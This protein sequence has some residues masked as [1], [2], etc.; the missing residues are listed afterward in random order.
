MFAIKA[1]KLLGEGFLW[2]HYFGVAVK[3]SKREKKLAYDHKV[4]QLLD[5]YNQVL[6]AEADNIRSNQLQNVRKGVS[7]DSVVIMSKN[8]VLRQTI[9]AHAEKTGNKAYLNLIPL[10]YGNVSLIFTKGDLKEVHDE[11]AKFKKGVK[12][13][14]AESSLLTKLG[15]KPYSLVVHSVYDNGSVYRPEVLELTED[16]IYKSGASILA[17]LSMALSYPIVALWAASPP[18][19]MDGSKNDMTM[20]AQPENSSSQAQN[21]Q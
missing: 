12:A 18:I 8:T 16:E 5:Q 6:V 2:R 1:R 4:C 21:V 19:G 11:V 17:S 10:L 14:S 3:S 20:N 15:M 13:G 9:K 7:Q